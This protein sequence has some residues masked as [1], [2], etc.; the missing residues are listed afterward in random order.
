MQTT[1]MTKKKSEGP[2]AVYGA[3]VANLV[4]A[5]SK[6]VAAFFTGS[7]A[8]LAEGIHS[9]VDTTNELF[10]LLGIKRSKRPADENHPFGHGMELYFWS[11]IVAVFLFALVEE[12]LFMKAFRIY[13]RLI[14]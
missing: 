4:I 10:L 9:V 6:F 1:E 3:I 11:F 13:S 14:K 7:S 2:I 12:C 8:M 5:A